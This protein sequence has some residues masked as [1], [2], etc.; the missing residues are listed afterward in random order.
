MAVE[1]RLRLLG[2]SDL[3]ANIFAYD[4]YRDR[5]DDTVGLAKTAG[6]IA[7]ARAEAVNSLLLDNGDVIQG[8]PLGDFAA[9]QAQRDASSIHPMIAAM[10]RLGYDAG[11]LGNHE[12]N[13]GL[14]VLE[15][16]LRA[17][18][19]PI[20]SCNILK[21]DGGFYFEPW[22]ILERALKDTNGVAR[23]LK[24]AVVG[25]TTPQIVQW[26]Q[27]HLAGKATTIGIAEA[28]RIHLPE[29]RRLGAD[30]V[31]A[32]CHSGISRKRFE[33]PG[34]ENAALAL[35]KVGGIDAIFIGHQHLLLPGAD[36]AGL[37]G[38]DAKAGALNG[39]P[40]V[41][42]G[43]WGSHLGVIDLTLEPKDAGWRVANAEAAARPIYE[44]D[45][46]TVRSRVDADP[47]LLE[48]A[49]PAHEATLAYVRAPVG[50]IASP[51]TSYFAL[52]ADD[53]SVQ[54][55]NSA[56]IW[57]MRRLIDT[58]P[59]LAGLPILSAAA[60]FKCGGRG[61]P[62]YYTD[63]AAGPVAIKNV[64]DLYV[65][66][67]GLRTV[68]VSGAML[69]EWLERSA[70]LFLRIDVG[71]RAPQP[72]LGA[73]FAA[74]NFDVIDGVGYAIDVT[75]P[76]RYDLDGALVAPQSHRILDLRYQG[77]PIDPARE[78]LVVTN[79]YRA[80]G[81]GNFPGCDGST[82]VYEAP[83]SNRDAL[84]RYI[85]ET[86]HVEPRSDGNW[87]FARWPEET[88]VTYLTSPSAAQAAA[89]AS[90]KATLVGPA[91]GGFAMYR[92]QPL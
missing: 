66:P 22:V 3:H 16:A 34:E 40:T 67:N 36:F 69:R 87:R 28:A 42:P 45:G 91:P 83:D 1:I 46:E 56:Q 89:P 70:S 19:F 43:F 57:Y 14:D 73:A 63:V 12:F 92:I 64:A 77:E 60:P 11:A 10:N 88:F 52:V 86:Q 7:A 80:G 90:V 62:D 51:I 33:I 17:A 75:Q 61:G 5:P 41:M 47:D 49:R 4:Y 31:I 50:D 13:Y 74:Y 68:K 25:F 78:F 2:T 82:I 58:L 38:V 81:G 21:P 48:V 8:T 65:Y 18:A 72:L 44:R 54:I 20:V 29:L 53:P 15:S 37:D 23:K 55:V 27:S 9:A 6:L 84:V 24:L 30:V 71:A 79:S 85:V 32:L 35:S 76:A 26:D 59:M 39:A